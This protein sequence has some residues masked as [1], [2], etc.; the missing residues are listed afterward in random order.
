MFIDS[1]KVNID[2]EY[3]VVFDCISYI[4]VEE[5]YIEIIY[6]CVIDKEGNI[7]LFMILIGMIYGSGIMILGYGVLLNIIMDGFDVVVGGI[8]EIVFYKWLLS[9]MVLM[10]VMYYGKLILIVGVFGVIS[11][12]V[13]VV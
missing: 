6:F 10:I 8:N 11:I 9:N 12:I 2:I 3:G 7:V 1:N 13:S 5:N 4:D